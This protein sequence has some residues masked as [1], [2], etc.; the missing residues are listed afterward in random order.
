M[1]AQILR[2][3]IY[4]LEFILNWI[5]HTFDDLDEDDNLDFFFYDPSVYLSFVFLCL[6]MCSIVFK[7]ID[8][9]FDSFN[10][11]G[12][13]KEQFSKKDKEP[14]SF[15]SRF[16]SFGPK[17]TASEPK[18]KKSFTRQIFSFFFSFLYSF[19]IKYVLWLFSLGSWI[20]DDYDMY[21]EDK[22]FDEALENKEAVAPDMEDD[23]ASDSSFDVEDNSNNNF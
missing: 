16:F 5:V 8:R 20:L 9:K 19:I 15:F 22:A 18:K 23:S 17:P 3:I 4:F 11:G 7:D 1:W 13:E 21:M 14:L 10:K 6:L 2:G 12:S